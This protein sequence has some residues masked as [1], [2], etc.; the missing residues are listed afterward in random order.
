M[1]DPTVLLPC[2]P[3]GGLALAEDGIP[4]RYCEG[5]GTVAMPEAERQRWL[6]YAGEPCGGSFLAAAVGEWDFRGHF[7]AWLAGLP[8]MGQIAAALGAAWAVLVQWEEQ[9]T[10]HNSMTCDRLTGSIRCVC[11]V[12]RRPR[13]ALE[14]CTAYL[15]EP[16]AER[17]EAWRDL[18]R[19]NA[20]LAHIGWLPIT[21][22]PI[23][24]TWLRANPGEGSVDHAAQLIG[25]DKAHDAARE[26]VLAWLEGRL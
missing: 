1:T 22:S 18:H 13:K 16:T 25:D 7:P 3:C 24:D 5:T 2:E 14:A 9:N 8:P 19:G 10:R 21:P 6:A 20:G 26:G 17:R 11:T 4:C 12:D 15:R 23:T